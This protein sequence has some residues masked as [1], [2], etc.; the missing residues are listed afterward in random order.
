MKKLH[1]L[2]ATALSGNDPLS[3][4]LYIPALTI[5]FAGKHAWISILIIG[6]MFLLYKVMYTNVS[7]HYLFNGGVYNIS[8]L[9]FSKLISKLIAIIS[10][11]TFLLLTTISLNEASRYLME[12]IPG[13]SPTFYSIGLISIIFILSLIGAKITSKF[14]VL[15]LI[16]FSLSLLIILIFGI[17]FLFKNGLGTLLS[18]FNSPFTQSS[19]AHAIVLGF[20]GGIFA[21]SG[22]ESASNYVEQQKKNIYKKVFNNIWLLYIIPNLIMIF[23]ILSIVKIPDLQSGYYYNTLIS[24]LADLTVGGNFTSFI[25]ISS[26]L[27]LFGAAISSFFGAVNLFYRLIQDRAIPYFSTNKKLNTAIISLI[28]YVLSISLLFSIKGNVMNII[29]LFTLSF[30]LL[31]LIFSINFIIFHFKYNISTSQSKLLFISIGII[32]IT[33]VAFALYINLKNSPQPQENLMA[34][35]FNNS[36]RTIILLVIIFLIPMLATK[37]KGIY[38]FTSKETINLKNALDYFKKNKFKDI[39]IAYWN[40]F[41]QNEVQIRQIK[42][43]HPNL[44]IEL[45][46]IDEPFS[47]KSLKELY[48]KLKLKENQVYLD[49][50]KIKQLRQND[51]ET[52]DIRFIANN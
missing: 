42:E 25:K 30:L 37:K 45:I 14:S 22:L 3:S 5:A 11:L 46:K 29:S 36:P 48:K 17:L 33:G 40:N 39:K 4:I 35:I 13:G 6:I 12:I 27:V 23:L 31:L 26:F 43:M 21:I 34:S 38:A 47:L 41:D 49:A 2:E 9:N 8:F 20:T 18:N 15:I 24:H 7:S 28:F 1:Q 16:V 44:N 51:V 50:S 19:P 32:S 10:L 52:G